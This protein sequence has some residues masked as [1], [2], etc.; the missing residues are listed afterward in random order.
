M[1]NEGRLR[2]AD[3]MSISVQKL[4]SKMEEELKQA[5]LQTQ[6]ENVREKVYSIKI[7]CE[8]ILDEN[9]PVQETAKNLVIERPVVNQPVFTVNQ[10][11]KLLSEDDANGESL[12]DF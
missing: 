1:Y 11:G 8:L 12:L 10:M 9:Q 7:L 4:L 5:K 6:G 3:G 2:G